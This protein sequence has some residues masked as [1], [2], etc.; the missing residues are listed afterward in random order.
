MTNNDINC[1]IYIQKTD[2]SYYHAMLLSDVCRII[3]TIIRECF[4]CRIRIRMGHSYIAETKSKTNIVKQKQI[5]LDL[6]VLAL[7][8]VKIY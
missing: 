1:I 6:Q 2:N 5:W 4:E 3:A 7:R 8:N